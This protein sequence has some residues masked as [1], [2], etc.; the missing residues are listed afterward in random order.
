VKS[1]AIVFPLALIASFASAAGLSS[2]EQKLPAAVERRLPEALA[3]LE[4]VVNLNSGTMNFE[5]V[6]ECGRLFAP[7]FERLGFTTRWVDGSAWNRAGHLIAERPGK[8]AKLHVLLIGH[9]D[10]VF[11]KD[12]PFQRWEMV[13]ETHARGP[14][15]I[16][17]K[18]GNV[19]MLLALGALRE[20]GELDRLNVTVVLSGDEESPG[21][22]IE[23]ARKDLIAAGEAAY[24]A[25]G[26][27]DG[28]GDPRT[29]VVARRGNS[30]WRL[31]TAGVPSHSSQIFSQDIGSGAIFE[32]ARILTA[33]EDSL[34]GEKF[35]SF[36]P[37]WVAG[38]TSIDADFEASRASA[39]GK[40]NVVAEST[41]V[42][43]DLRTI[44][45]EQRERTKAAMERIVSRHRPHTE[46]R[47]EFM[48]RY[49]PLAP[50][51]GNRRL[52]AMFDQASGDL[53]QGPVTEVSPDQAG[54]ADISFT[55]GLVD[56]ALDGI[57]LMGTGGH[58][59]R[60][61]ADLATLGMQ[62]SRTAVM[63]SRL[64]RGKR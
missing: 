17:M 7:E 4:R 26:I 37:G 41:I 28:D 51:D 11:E 52:L 35:L 8:K 61:T 22:P 9:L 19:V 6:R 31:R 16:D 13:D 39:F 42:A 29:A 63:L 12:A 46:A 49:P 59:V 5:G 54:A 10:T 47:I 40:S 38:G 25:L 64:A 3:F 23:L 56:M 50:T 2:V 62:A 1:A 58:T 55:A 36:N 44:S 60:E 15:A 27:E 48:D 14:G 53:G 32:A 57:G 21:K 20:A 34:A 24:I 45:P 30:E 43:G 18:G 33:F